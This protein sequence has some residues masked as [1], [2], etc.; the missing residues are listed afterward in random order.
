MR[1]SAI[2]T[3]EDGPARL[4][5]ALMLR[6]VGTCSFGMTL[7]DARQHD[8]PLIYAN[9][10]FASMTGYSQN[11]IHGEN[12]RFLQGPDTDPASISRIRQTIRSER[13]E[14]FLLLNYRK[15]GSRFWNRFQLSPVHDAGNRLIA[16]L[17]MQVDITDDVDRLGLEHERQKLETLGRLAGGVAHELN[18]AL[19]PIQ[20]YAELLTDR[21]APDGEHYDRCTNG[22]LENAKFAGD[23]VSQILSF[24]R[25]DEIADQDYEARAVIKEAVDFASEYVPSSL[26]VNRR[27]FSSAETCAGVH[28]RIN[29]TALFQ[30]IANLFKNAAD[31]CGS[32]GRISVNLA[33]AC[34][35]SKPMTLDQATASRMAAG[36]PSKSSYFVEI[37]ITDNGQ[38]MDRETLQHV[39]EPFFTTKAPGKGVGLGLSTIYGIVERWGGRV[40]V[41]STPRRGSTFRVLIPV[42]KTA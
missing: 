17:G 23:V 22:I 3:E 6:A 30:V 31:A 37:E 29:R 13:A 4:P 34:D 18:N 28:I 21:P 19:Q 39:F 14:T 8:M 32:D 12:C 26:T 20:L 42:S 5:A 15:D 33:L 1:N 2:C 10:A 27:G 38:G 25:G 24:A 36:T 9:A 41:T 35:A 40:H 16:Y 11:E 7:A